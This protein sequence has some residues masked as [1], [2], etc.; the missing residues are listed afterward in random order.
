MGLTFY[1]LK[2]RFPTEQAAQETLPKV[3][4][5]LERM[6]KAENDWQKIRQQRERRVL[7]RFDALKAKYSDVFERLQLSL[8]PEAELATDAG[9]NFLSGE[10]DSPARNEDWKIWQRGKLLGFHGEVWHLADWSGLARAMK[11]FGAIRVSWLNDEDLD[12]YDALRV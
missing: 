1:Y 5:F 8:P 9:M 10:L 12:P 2:A 3:T 6:A 7:E 4:M 11:T